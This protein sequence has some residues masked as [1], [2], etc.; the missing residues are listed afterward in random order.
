MKNTFAKQCQTDLF[1]AAKQRERR[2]DKSKKYGL[3]AP[4]QPTNRLSDMWF[5]DNRDRVST[6]T[7]RFPDYRKTSQK[8]KRQ[9][10]WARIPTFPAPAYRFAV[11]RAID[12]SPLA[13]R[14][15]CCS[16]EKRQSVRRKD[17]RLRRL[18]GGGGGGGPDTRVSIRRMDDARRT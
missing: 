6:R 13:Q 17:E 16:R 11:A 18:G 3:F 14:V 5:T 1:F 2:F 9:P 10:T 12:R 7:T 4:S 15:Q 8:D